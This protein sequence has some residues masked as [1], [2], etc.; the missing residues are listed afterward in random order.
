VSRRIGLLALRGYIVFA[1]VMMAVKLIEV[2]T[3]R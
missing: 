1:V 2:T 3:A